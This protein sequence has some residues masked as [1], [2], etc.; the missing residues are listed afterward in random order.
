MA[1]MLSED[2]LLEDIDRLMEK[3]KNTVSPIEKA[4]IKQEINWLLEQLTIIQRKKRMK[5]SKTT[6]EESN[7]QW[8]NLQKIARQEKPNVGL[9]EGTGGQIDERNNP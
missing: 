3:L 7:K 1:K 5:T 2:K 8:I 4:S 6:L 9:F